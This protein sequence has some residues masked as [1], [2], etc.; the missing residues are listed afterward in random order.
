MDFV[1]IPVLFEET[2]DAL[3]IKPD[4]IYVDG[5]AGG[6]GHARAIAGRLTTGH[7]YALDRDPDAVATATERLKPYPATVIQSNFDRMDLAL[8]E[9][10][11]T[12]ADGVLLDLGVSSFQLD[13]AERGFSYLKDAP[14]DM[15]MS[16]EGTSAYD[17]VNGSEK[18]ALAEIFQT[19]GEEKF[20][21]RIAEKIVR[22]REKSPIATTGQLAERTPRA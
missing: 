19:Y 12:E 22:E 6:A 7:L 5:T 11:V 16:K 2:I 17:L 10:S 3:A 15:R 20:A 1:H 9:F 14:L 8:K 21:F 13:E 18:E 4:G